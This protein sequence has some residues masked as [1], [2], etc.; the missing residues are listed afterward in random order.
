[1]RHGNEDA[2][3]LGGNACRPPTMAVPATDV[4]WHLIGVWRKVGAG[5]GR[6]IVTPYEVAGWDK[7]RYV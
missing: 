1:V 6:G 3:A 2:S 7:S 5:R 4:A